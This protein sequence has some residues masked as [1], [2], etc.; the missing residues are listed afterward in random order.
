MYRTLM[1]ILLIATF[2]ISASTQSIS[3]FLKDQIVALEKEQ[4]LITE[5]RKT[6]L[7]ELARIIS[8][9][10]ESTGHTEVTFVCTHN[11]RRSQLS[12]LWLRAGASYYKIKGIRTYSGGTAATAFNPRMVDAVVR[13][14]FYLHKSGDSVNPRYIAKLGPSDKNEMFSKK[15]DDP[16]NPNSDFVAVMVCSQADKDC[17]FVPGAFAR[18]ALPYEDPKAYDNTPEEKQAY[19]DKVREIG[20]EILYLARMIKQQEN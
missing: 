5:S 7:Q 6:E 18:V 4:V 20:R 10:Q 17:P 8:D 3:P 15:Y 19:D 2:M 16:F 9:H 1:V 13:F 11:S 14:G 12:E